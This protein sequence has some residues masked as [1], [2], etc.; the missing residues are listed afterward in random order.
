[1]R[2]HKEKLTKALALTVI[3]MHILL[4]WAAYMVQ[5][6][7]EDIKKIGAAQENQRI[8][9][10]CLKIASPITCVDIIQ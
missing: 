10:S 8:F 4:A 9:E 2:I 1:M 3:A 7:H 6:N 5:K